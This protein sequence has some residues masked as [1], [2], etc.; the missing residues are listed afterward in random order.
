MWLFAY[1]F[2]LL[3]D[4]SGYT[5]IAI[6]FGRLAGL[7]LPENFHH[8][9]LASSIS[10]F[11]QRWHITLSTWVRDYIF[12]PL[13]RRLR[14][15]FGNRGRAAVQLICHLATMGAVGLWHGLNPGFLVWGLWH[16]IGL[17]VHG[18]LAPR[19][20]RTVS[21]RVVARQLRLG[22][23]VGAT[24]LFVMLGW[25]F[26]ASDLPTALQIFARLFGIG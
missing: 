2:Y 18:Q 4:F 17:F 24:Y 12:F 9:Y 6:G 3:A 13:A 19:L 5:S 14:T 16:G 10:V 15:R 11:W 26:F 22:L 25:V 8:P 7:N 23:S 1:S 20:P 21:D